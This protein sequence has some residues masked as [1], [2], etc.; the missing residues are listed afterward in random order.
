MRHGLSEEKGK[1]VSSTRTFL[2]YW[3]VWRIKLILVDIFE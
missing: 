1:V 3:L 2:L